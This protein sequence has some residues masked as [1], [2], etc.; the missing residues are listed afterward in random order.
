MKYAAAPLL[1]VAL[2]AAAPSTEVEGRYFTLAT[3]AIRYNVG[4]GAFASDAAVRITKTG[5]EA[6]ADRAEGNTVTGQATLRGNVRV[7]DAGGPGS[8]QGKNAKP[9]LLT[10]DQL[11]VDGRADTYKA[12]GHAHYESA[13]RTA[14]AD[15]MLLDRKAKKLHLEGGVTITQGDS[16][17]QAAAVDVDLKTGRSVSTGSPVILSRPASGRPEAA[18]VSPNP[19]PAPSPSPQ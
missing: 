7:R 12:A 3:S 18:P 1:A 4:T 10:C 8:V 5:L 6:S 14:S 13:D 17:A 15:T 9:A 2:L 19:R 11:E 16:T